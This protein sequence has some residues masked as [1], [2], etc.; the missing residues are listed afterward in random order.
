MASETI[1][2]ALPKSWWFFGDCMRRSGLWPSR[3]RNLDKKSFIG[4]VRWRKLPFIT[5]LHRRNRRKGSAW[6]VRPSPM[7]VPRATPKAGRTTDDL[8]MGQQPIRSE[9][10]VTNDFLHRTVSSWFCRLWWYCSCSLPMTGRLSWEDFLCFLLT[11]F[12]IDE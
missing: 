4:A 8:A 6:N 5:P 3:H 2:S 12:K 10:M 11:A 7:A 1:L 9:T